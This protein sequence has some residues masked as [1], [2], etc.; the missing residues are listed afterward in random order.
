MRVRTYGRLADLLGTEREV[1]IDAP[2]TVA[3]LRLQLANDCP[4][5]AE[6]LKNK[7]VRACVGDAIVSDS[8]MLSP[9]EALELLAPVSGG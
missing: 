2:C 4:E 3:E 9:D 6:A 1:G 5:A 8:Y 7:R